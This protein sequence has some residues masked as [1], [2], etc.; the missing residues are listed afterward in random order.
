MLA[1][2]N[3]ARQLEVEGLNNVWVTDITY[4]TTYVGWLYLA[5]VIEL[6]SR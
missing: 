5:V 1:D 3:L 4:I 6:Y 2:N